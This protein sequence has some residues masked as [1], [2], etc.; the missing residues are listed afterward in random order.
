[1]RTCVEHGSALDVTE[2][3]DVSGE[4]EQVN[5]NRERELVDASGERQSR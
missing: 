3:V 1:V 5:G 2:Q 4:R